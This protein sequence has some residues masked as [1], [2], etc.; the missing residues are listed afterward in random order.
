MTSSYQLISE[1]SEKQIEADVASFFGYMTPIFGKRLKLIDVN[2]QL[3]GADKADLT[4]GR[5]YFFQF[6]KPIGLQSTAKLPIPLV[7]RKNESKL[8]NV[9]RFRQ[10]HLLGDF[11]YS[12]SFALH[13]EKTTPVNE[14]Q[15]NVLF[16]YEQPDLSRA[17]YICPTTLK[18]DEY[19]KLLSVPFWERFWSSPYMGTRYQT[20]H[21]LNACSQ[22]SRCP[23]LRGHVTVVP[24]TQVTSPDHYYSF[25][26]N[27]GDIAFHSPTII[28]RESSRL[29]DFLHNELRKFILSPGE[30]PS[31]V[32]VA[33]R[34]YKIS[35]Q[36]F[37]RE[38]APPSSD[39]SL[40]WLQSHGKILLEKYSIRQVIIAG[41]IDL[42][43]YDMEKYLK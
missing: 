37:D 42:I 34:V 24:H 13:G 10:H 33:Q 40:E 7:P 18:I 28:T 38:I 32:E 41:N 26:K 27:G 30:L 36:I 17:M 15:H 8:M 14:L 12:L 35:A 23:F 5:A 1:L 2:E 21:G 4:K 19:D 6:K 9:R 22:V 16:Q 3:T 29:S 31:L 43:E 39:N 11:P 20:V 25:A